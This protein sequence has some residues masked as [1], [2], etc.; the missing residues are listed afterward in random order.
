MPGQDQ[1]ADALTERLLKIY[2]D[3][4]ALNYYAYRFLGKVRRDGGL[5]SAQYY[6][7]PSKRATDGFQRLL[8]HDRLDLS[9]EAVVLDEP[10]WQRFFTQAELRTARERLDQFGYFARRAIAVVESDQLSADE[11]EDPA[12]YPEGEKVQVTASAYER[13]PV[14]RQKCIDH[15]G[16]K[17]YVCGFDYGR[18]YGDLGVGRIQVHHLTPFGD[19]SKPRE[20]NPIADLRPVCANCHWML[21][22]RS[23][24]VA[25]ADLKHIVTTMSAAAQ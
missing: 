20:T 21:H 23:P 3:A 8:D 6:L 14:A 1:Q 25:I 11:F 13:N 7:R 9:V 16:A 19:G 24:P 5:K 15:Y 2:E 4:K 18:T 22:R 17:C 12:L 10:Q